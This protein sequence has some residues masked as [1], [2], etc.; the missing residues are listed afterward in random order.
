[1]TSLGIALIGYPLMLIAFLL[2]VIYCDVRRRR[3][4]ELQAELEE[5]HDAESARDEYEAELE[6]RYQAEIEHSEQYREWQ[7]GGPAPSGRLSRF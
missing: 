6:A 4:A 1:M 7:A 5:R 3:A 2:M